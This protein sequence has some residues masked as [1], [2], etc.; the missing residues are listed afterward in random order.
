MISATDLQA[1]FAKVEGT[2]VGVDLMRVGQTTGY[3][4]GS[5][6]SK[7]NCIMVVHNVF[8]F[9]AYFSGSNKLKLNKQ[10]VALDMEDCLDRFYGG[11]F[12]GESS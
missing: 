7:I 4:N 2:T 3:G 11:Y 6:P 12:S 9:V 5:F 1:L 10:R 8:Y